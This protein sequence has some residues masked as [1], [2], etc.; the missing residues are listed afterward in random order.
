MS[1]AVEAALQETKRVNGPLL[2]IPCGMD[3][4]CTTD[5]A[6]AKAYGDL[7]RSIEKSK[8]G[9]A[10]AAVSEGIRTQGRFIRESGSP[11]RTSF[12]K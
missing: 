12:P 9:T 6:H 1:S 5:A 2:T 7:Y 4:T 3:A 11:I 8:V 10:V